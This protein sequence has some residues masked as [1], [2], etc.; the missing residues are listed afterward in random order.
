MPLAP[1]HSRANRAILR[2][3]LA[4]RFPLCAADL[5]A[6]DFAA[7]GGLTLLLEHQAFLK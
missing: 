5:A 1:G 4:R 3:V 2:L 6:P 7:T